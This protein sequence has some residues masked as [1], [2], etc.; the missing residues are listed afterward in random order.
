[1]N[2]GQGRR[3]TRLFGTSGIRG[4][5]GLDVTPKL[6]VQVGQALA[7]YT[8]AEA[9]LIAHDTRTTSEML[10]SALAAGITACGAAALLQG[11]APTP[12]LAFLTRQMGAGAGVMVTASHNPPEFNG[13]K[14]YN[15]DTTAYN[16]AQQSEIEK[17]VE[18]QDFKLA[19]WENIGKTIAVDETQQYLQMITKNIKLRKSWKIVLDPGNGATSQLAPAIFRQLGC[20]VTAIN[21]QPDGHFPGRGAEPSRESLGSLSNLVRNLKA[22]MG[23]AFDGDGDRM[24]SVDEKG[25]VTPLD[26]TFA[27]YAAQEISRQRHKTVVTHVEASMCVEK[28]VEAK[29]GKV[30]RTKVGDVSITEAIKRHNAAFGGEPCGAWIHPSFHYCPDGMLSS[31]RLL[32]ALEETRLDLSGFISQVPR[33]PLLRQNIACPDSFKI[34]LMNKLHGALQ[35]SFRGI[36]EET[37]I[38]GIRLTFERGWLLVRPSGT[39]PLIRVTVEAETKKTATEIMKKTVNLVGTLVREAG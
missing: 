9:V 22:D 10:E 17:L 18:K 14:L 21:A 30:F 37:K 2:K 34:T 31:I 26:Q 11:L 19:S 23:I 32:Q 13:L 8:R 16:A 12:V 27:A 39:E 6:A 36:K 5:V 3:L 24:I 20:Q 38:D 33:Y 35:S 4:V 29:G 25:R 1:M 15:P 28:M 7:S